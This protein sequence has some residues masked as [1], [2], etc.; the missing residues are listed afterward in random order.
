MSKSKYGIISVLDIGST[1]IVC[2]VVRMDMAGNSEIIG[3]GH[4][5]SQ[6]FRAG[7][8][9]DI[10]LA[11]TSI[12]NCIETAEKMAQENIEKII[13]NISGNRIT[14]HHLVTH[15]AIGPSPITERDIGRIITQSLE[16]YSQPET[17]IIHTIPLDYSIDGTDGIKDPVRMVGKQ[18]TGKLHL[19]TAPA[20]SIVNLANCLA[21]C[22][23]SVADFII[24]PYAAGLACLTNDEMELG[25]A[26]IDMGGGT[27]SFALFKSGNMIYA[28]SI[29]VGGKHVTSDIARGLSTDMVNAERIKTLY[30]NAICTNA[31]HKEMINVPYIGEEDEMGMHHIP[32]ALLA[33]IIAP[34][35]EE[36]LEM[37]K[38]QLDLSG[39][40]S[41]VGQNIVITGG[42]SQLLGLKELA[43]RILGKHVRIGYPKA[44]EGL[45]EST[46]GTAF[47]TAIGMVQFASS[48]VSHAQYD[49]HEQNEKKGRVSKLI[50]WLQENF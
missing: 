35:I 15:A 28:D 5:I 13:V 27:T 16:Q 33:E 25:S 3:I 1:K 47:S 50:R 46:K 6:G 48:K 19:V 30:G 11:E 4:Q 39:F 14:S 36:T 18:L 2:F 8:I 31:D 41:L 22:Q 45:A 10:K 9:T 43:G 26:V 34:R 12:L 7:T 44:L 24:S 17:D 29:A 37:I 32:R 23:L 49:L 20:T 40:A 38:H 42:A 21:R